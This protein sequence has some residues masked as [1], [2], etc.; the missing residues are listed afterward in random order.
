[1]RGL[2][3]GFGGGQGVVEAVE[4][5]EEVVNAECVI[6]NAEL[7]NF[8][9][10]E[11]VVLFRVYFNLIV[12]MLSEVLL[13]QSEVLLYSNRRGER[14]TDLFDFGKTFWGANPCMMKI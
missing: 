2:V 9:R 3:Q 10:G 8:C 11:V 4:R 1:M 5:R 12:F 14:N 13:M 6:R 7:V